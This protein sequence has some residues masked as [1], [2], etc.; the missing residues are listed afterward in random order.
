MQTDVPLTKVIARSTWNPAQEIR[1]PELGHLNVGAGDDGVVFNLRSGDVGFLD[2]RNVLGHGA[3]K[4]ERELTLRDGQVAW[5]RN[6]RAG[7]EYTEPSFPQTSITAPRSERP[8]PPDEP[9]PHKEIQSC[10]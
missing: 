6:G 5:D 2:V 10:P 9:G 4:L 8:M 1:G 3:K 7:G